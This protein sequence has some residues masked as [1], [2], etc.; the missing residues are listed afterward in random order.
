MGLKELFGKGKKKA[1]FRE[2]AKEVLAK[3]KLTPDK[4]AALDALRKA[5]E[6]DDPGDDKTMLRREI[7]NQAA[8]TAKARGKL[9]ESEAT[10]LAKIQKFLALRDD[11]VER[12]KWDLVGL[13]TLT[14]IR[15]GRLPAVQYSPQADI[16]LYAEGLRLQRTVGH[17]LL[18]FKS[19]S[20]DTSEIVGELLSALMR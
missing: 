15:Q 12:T 2:K 6:I 7:Y 20:N 13:R 3:G 11:Q 1:E 14:E 5:H 16:F 19:G 18:K 10:E 9:S 4:T 8:G 17:T